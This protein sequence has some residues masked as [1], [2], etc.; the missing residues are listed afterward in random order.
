MSTT[1]AW[2]D[3]T[4]DM[5]LSGYVEELDVLTGAI[6]STSQT[7]ITVQGVASSWAKGVVFEVNS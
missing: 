4:R 7:T 5:L 3:A 6:S 2:I 1:Q